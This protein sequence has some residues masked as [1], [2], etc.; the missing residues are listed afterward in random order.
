MSEIR[1]IDVTLYDTDE[2]WFV[3]FWDISRELLWMQCQ[4]GSRYARIL[5]NDSTPYCADWLRITWWENWNYHAMK[6]HIDDIVIFVER[7]LDTRSE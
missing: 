4:Y 5:E 2:N 6:I 1:K 7:V 3:S